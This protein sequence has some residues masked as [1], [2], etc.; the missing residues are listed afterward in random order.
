[1]SS[2][3]RRPHTLKREK[4]LAMPRHL[5]FFDTE[6]KQE[7]LPNGEI[8][9][10]LKLGWACYWRRAYG[11]N[12]EQFVWLN[13]YS[14]R[15]FW[16][17]VAEHTEPK[18]KLWVLARNLV[19]DFTITKG[20]KYLRKSGFKLKF[21]HS[22]GTCSI[23]SVKSKGGS[24]V[25]LDIMNWFVESLEKTGQ[26][27]GM[28]KIKI[29]F[30]TCS[31]SELN[32]YGKRDVEIELEN[33]KR[34]IKFLEDNSVARL[35]YTRASTAMAAYLLGH[36]H[37]K[38]YIH[39]NKEAIDLERKSYRGGRTECFCLGEF[40]DDNYFIVDV[41]SL[42]PFVMRNNR[43]PVKYKKILNH[44]TLAD[45][46]SELATSQA[47][48]EVLIDTDEPVYAVKHDRTIFPIGRFWVTLTTPEL[49]YAIKHNHL[50]KIKQAVFYRGAN[51]FK[52]YV[53]RFYGLRQRFKAENNPEYIE[54]CKKLLN[55]LYGKFGQKAEEWR[56]IGNC[57]DEPDRV[58]ICFQVGYSG[59]KHIR[60]LLGE[61]FELV[62]YDE[63]FNSFPAIAAHV[64]A[65]GRLYLFDLMKITG[66]GNYFYCDTDSLIINETGLLN[67]QSQIDDS[68]LGGLKIEETT[69]RVV[70][71]GL[72]D[73]S[74]DSK[75]VIKGIRKNA[76]RLSEGV[77]EQQ[78]WPSF[79]GVL[80]GND[81]N[82]YKIHKIIK[83]LHREYTKGTV[84]EDGSISPFVLDETAVL[85]LRF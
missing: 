30:E 17:F 23:I 49:K 84:N 10:Y 41:N 15:D 42:Y 40:E 26:R 70:I 28:P 47:T 33:F 20:W 11:R 77:Y 31:D 83:H 4:T 21:F 18:R 5:I 45:F 6:T 53:D 35:C 59:V 12:R 27:I 69:N 85:P 2:I 55:S 24:I 46:T 80:R 19:F 29:D 57:P 1:M 61:I 78:Q 54:L 36:Y 3:K 38:I 67:L 63:C 34:F 37:K 71:R 48:A 14:S 52:T 65:Y 66:E 32:I 79:K 82:V 74:T 39:N 8:R 16:Q 73:Y 7:I 60:Y 22:T 76:V 51:I 56:K 68:I 58:E 81:A 75:T 25:F 72:K 44:I 64:A 9:Q 62:G 13:F 43:Y 50:V